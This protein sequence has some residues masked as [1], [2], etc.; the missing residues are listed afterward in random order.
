M[1]VLVIE[2]Q[3]SAFGLFISKNQQC[4]P[5][6]IKGA[7]LDLSTAGMLKVV[8]PLYSGMVKPHLSTVPIAGP[9]VD[10]NIL[11]RVLPRAT[12]MKR[13]EQ[14]SCEERL[15]ELELF[16]LESWNCSGSVKGLYAHIHS[17]GRSDEVWHFSAV[18][19]DWT[20]SNQKSKHWKRL[21]SEIVKPPSSKTLKG[22]VNRL[23]INML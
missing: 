5:V 12:K 21:F 3:D 23:M 6:N 2:M 19:S 7:A 16:S 1:G 22:Q 11:E 20:N 14:L 18:H 8:L 17:T 15:R 10:I 4:T 13:Q 9:P